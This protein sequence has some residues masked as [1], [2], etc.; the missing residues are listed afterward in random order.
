MTGH[1][2]LRH[3]G[4]QLANHRCVRPSLITQPLANLQQTTDKWDSP[5][6][7]SWASP[8]QYWPVK[9]QNCYGFKTP[10]F[11]GIIKQQKLTYTHN[12]LQ[13]MQSLDIFILESMYGPFLPRLRLVS[14]KCGKIHLL[15]SFCLLNQKFKFG[16]LSPNC[17]L[18]NGCFGN[19]DIS[20]L[21]TLCD[22]Q[23]GFKSMNTWSNCNCN[24]RYRQ[25]PLA[26]Y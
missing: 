1:K 8:D 24:L 14:Y 3:L 13:S 23:V 26:Q 25:N 16:P 22:W 21:Y 6:E 12:W 15:P 4:Q 11:G 7:I 19:H 18:W 9:P 17:R 5:A 20:I 10:G 2:G